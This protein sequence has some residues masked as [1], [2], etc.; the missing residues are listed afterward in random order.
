MALLNTLNSKITIGIA[1]LLLVPVV[2]FFGFLEF[3]R[4]IPKHQPANITKA[5]AIVV[6]T[7]GKSRIIDA[8]KLL[9]AG[10]GGRLLISGVH[11]ATSREALAKLLPKQGHL[12]NCCVDLDKAARN[13]IGNAAET[14]RWVSDH[15]FK[16]L[17]IVT[18]SYHMPRSL[19]ELQHA[20]P[21]VTLLAYPVLVNS[22][23]VTRWWTNPGTAQLLL[24]EYVKYL[25]THLRL[26]LN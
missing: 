26:L 3:T 6:L 14:A 15:N 20:L 2:F 7:G 1:C 25:A 11:R 22:V 18:S 4:S 5:D 23:P 8:F 9:D 16:S 12:L 19:A 17:I 13:T 10:K 21:K 24:S